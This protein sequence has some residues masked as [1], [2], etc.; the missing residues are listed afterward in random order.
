MIIHGGYIDSSALGDCAN[1]GAVKTL[2]SED[3]PGGAQDFVARI[4]L[5]GFNGL[6]FSCLDGHGWILKHMFET[7]K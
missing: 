2:F 6:L 3:L 4:F 1:R 5:G 7:V